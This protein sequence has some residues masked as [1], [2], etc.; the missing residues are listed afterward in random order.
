M[1]NI[2]LMAKIYILN[3]DLQKT[4]KEKEEVELLLKESEKQNIELRK[5]KTTVISLLNKKGE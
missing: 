2:D 1:T 4:K 5:F 3:R